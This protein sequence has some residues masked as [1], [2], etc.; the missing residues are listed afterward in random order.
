MDSMTWNMPK[1][2]TKNIQIPPAGPPLGKEILT[3][4]AARQPLG[5]S[6]WRTKYVQQSEFPSAPKNDSVA[7]DGHETEVT[8][9]E[10]CQLKLE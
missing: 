4:L 10:V 6:C 9:A 8:L 1:H 3:V 2:T 5:M 7:E